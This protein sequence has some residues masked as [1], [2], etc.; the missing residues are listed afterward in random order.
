MNAEEILKIIES[1]P[2]YIRYIYPGYLSMYLYLFFRGK[3][4]KDSNYVLLK[5]ITIS[6]I[7]LWIVEWIRELNYVEK[8]N[9]CLFSSMPYEL[10]F[11]LL[12]IVIASVIPYL[13]Y[14]ISKSSLIL[15]I[16]QVFRINTT[17]YDNEIE[18]LANYDEGAW[19]VVYLKDD[20]VV[21]EGSLGDKELEDG[22]RQY[23]CL[24]SFSKYLLK[25]DGKPKEPY[26]E[27]H[28]EEPEE[29]VMIFYES[30]KRIERKNA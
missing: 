21:Y 4:L 14:R 18:A 5:A 16:F 20:N 13:F 25:K 27:D 6:Y 30:I 8:L 17:F 1:L 23:I 7:Y 22:K 10:K 26:I 15:K 11:N 3:T 2:G 19:L 24:N 29:T 9:N 12:V 28:P